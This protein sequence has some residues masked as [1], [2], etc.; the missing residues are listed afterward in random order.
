MNPLYR[1]VQAND[2]YIPVY[3][4]MLFKQYREIKKMLVKSESLRYDLK[5]NYSD[6]KVESNVYI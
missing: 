6:L 5:R 1:N 4:F 2:L 3:F